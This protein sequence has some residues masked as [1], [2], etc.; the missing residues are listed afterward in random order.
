MAIDPIC[1]MSVDPARAAGKHEH[2]G[3]VFYFCSQH[4]LTKFKEAPEKLLT[5]PMQDHA[6][7]QSSVE[8]ALAATDPVCGM[9]VEANKAAGKHEHKGQTYYFCSQHCLNRFKEDPEKI[10]K[11]TMGQIGHE[12]PHG[13]V[14]TQQPTAHAEKVTG[15]AYV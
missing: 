5:A 2:N 12:Q 4:C 3:E 9:K 8:Y 13:D 7:Q 1:G 14:N 11:P 10:L 15:G 6:H